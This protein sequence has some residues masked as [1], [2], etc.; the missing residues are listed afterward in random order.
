ME[1]KTFEMFAGYGTGT[2]AL[3]ELGIKHKLVGFSEVDKFAIQCFEQ[4]HGGKNFGDATKINLED[5]EDFD[6]LFAGFPCQAFSCAGKSLG[7]LDTRGTLFNE[8]IRICEAKK[9][10]YMLLENVKGLTTK[11][12]RRTFEKIL[13]ELIR[14]GYHVEYKVLNSKNYGVPQ[15]R[16]RVWFACFRDVKDKLK[17][18]WP[19]KRELNIFVKDILE[20][21]VDE[22]YYIDPDI[23]ITVMARQ[24]A[25]W[26]GNFIR[27]VGDFPKFIVAS[28]G[29]YYQSSHMQGGARTKQKLEARNDG[30]SNSLTSVQ[31]DNMVVELKT[32]DNLRIR[33]LTPTECFRLQGFMDDQ[34][35]LEGISDTQR[36][37]LAGNGQT[38][39]VVTEIIRQM[40]N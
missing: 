26:R 32:T 19:G 4:N 5:V 10:K 3:K 7:E 40:L 21:E 14:I 25:S 35:N 6:F 37:K 12:H 18:E 13:S 28:R 30:L 1:L 8:I 20:P 22:R 36:Y 34:I 2:F 38:L 23:A 15:N 39:S 24:Y 27:K 33:R 16:E 11:P 31:K 29:R 17:F 9:P